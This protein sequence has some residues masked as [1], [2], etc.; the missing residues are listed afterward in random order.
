MNG[1]QNNIQA[2]LSES[3]ILL[4]ILNDFQKKVLCNED[5]SFLKIGRFT[6]AKTII[7][8][9]NFEDI[10]KFRLTC[11]DINFSCS[12]TIALVSYYKSTIKNSKSDS[13]KSS[14]TIMLKQFDDINNRILDNNLADDVNAE[15][16]TL[17][18]I[19]VFLSKKLLE[20]ENVIRIFKNDIEY[21]RGE[22]KTQN[23][24]NEKLSENFQNAQYELQQ[25]KKDN[26]HLNTKNEDLNKKN[27]DDVFFKF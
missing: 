5:N 19:R 26:L 15:L 1:S 23:M 13:Q 7:P 3:N 4:N 10:T 2:I 11:K 6:I 20:S 16:D 25:V 14:N 21:L 9:L 17:K 12:S 8:F 24:I 22:L 18:N 27:Q